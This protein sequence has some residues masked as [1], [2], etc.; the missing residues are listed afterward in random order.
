MGEQI[1]A[2][3]DHADLGTL[4]CDI[5]VAI[6]RQATV[7]IVITDHVAVDVDMTAVDLLQMI[8]A[9]Q[10]SALAGTGRADNH[11]HFVFPH[12]EVDISSAH[13]VSQS[14]C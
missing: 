6:F 12:F 13:A 14:A 3:K 11:D 8:D 10:E 7:A 9:A 4:A 1:E 2:L 5:P